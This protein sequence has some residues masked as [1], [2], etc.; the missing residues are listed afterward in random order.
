MTH[1]IGYLGTVTC[2]VFVISTELLRIVFLKIQGKA[3]DSSIN[4]HWFITFM[5][6]DKI[7]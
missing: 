1:R 3:T 7:S 2:K 4:L 5:T 6:V